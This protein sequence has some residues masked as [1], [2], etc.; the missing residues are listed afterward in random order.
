[1]II[2]SLL[3]LIIIG[4]GLLY[5]TSFFFDDTTRGIE[6]HTTTCESAGRNFSALRL[7]AFKWK[8]KTGKHGKNCKGCQRHNGLHSFQWANSLKIKRYQICARYSH[9]FSVFYAKGNLDYRIAGCKNMAPHRPVLL[10]IH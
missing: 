9:R 2:F 10:P 8:E 6:N 4:G 1:M 7:Q 5:T 3:L